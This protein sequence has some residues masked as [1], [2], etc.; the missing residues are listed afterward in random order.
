MQP[1]YIASYT[2][3]SVHSFRFTSAYPDRSFFELSR[4]NPSWRHIRLLSK[5]QMC[6]R[7]YPV[8][9]TPACAIPRALTLA[10]RFDIT[11]GSL[12]W[13]SN[14]EKTRWFLVLHAQKPPNDDL[15]RLLKLSNR[16][17]ASFGQPPLYEKTPQIS[18]AE[19]YSQCF[20]ISLAWALTEPSSDDKKRVAS[21]DLQELRGFNIRFDCVKAKIGNNVSS[22]PL[23]SGIFDQK[24]IGGL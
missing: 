9:A 4:D 5:T 15:N 19:D 6:H 7:E 3:T 17:L 13:V 18:G 12:E 11:L 21:I 8:T 14:Y 22:I 16:C 20:H 1:R 10:S 23:P 24:G 2:V